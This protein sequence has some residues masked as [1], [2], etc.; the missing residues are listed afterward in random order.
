MQVVELLDAPGKFHQGGDL[1]QRE[2]LLGR[3]RLLQQGL[4]EAF[5]LVFVAGAFGFGCLLF[6][7]FQ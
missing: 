4:D 2:G 3:H 5:H 6:G 7:S 1:R